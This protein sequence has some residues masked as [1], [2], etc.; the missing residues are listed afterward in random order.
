MQKE[1][2]IFSHM[3]KNKINKKQKDNMSV[4][5]VLQGVGRGLNVCVRKEIQTG[6]KGGS[7]SLRH[8]GCLHENIIMKHIIDT[9]N[10]CE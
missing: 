5:K 4:E 8:D 7:T 3:Y 10:V 9:V 2:F 1:R 6:K